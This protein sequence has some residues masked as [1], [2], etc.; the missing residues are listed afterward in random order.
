MRIVKLVRY[1]IEMSA[2]GDPA[3]G[4]SA[5]GEINENTYKF[6]TNRFVVLRNF[7]PKEIIEFTMDVWKT[8]EAQPELLSLIHI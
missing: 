4:R 8:I 2:H 5:V 6:Y 7:I 1:K 3:V